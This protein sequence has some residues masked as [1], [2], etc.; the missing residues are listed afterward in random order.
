MEKK[1]KIG[2]IIIWEEKDKYFWNFKYP[3]EEHDLLNLSLIE[4]DNN[5]IFNTPIGILFKNKKERDFKELEDYDSRTMAIWIK[6]P[7]NH[8]VGDE[9]SVEFKI[10]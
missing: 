5:S 9:I 2:Q 3:T 1:Y 8:K 6:R 4:K 10:K 7:H